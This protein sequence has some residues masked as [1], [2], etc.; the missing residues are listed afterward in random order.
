MRLDLGLDGVDGVV[1][2]PACGDLVGGAQ[3]AAR[4]GRA[5][6]FRARRCR[7]LEVARLL[8]GLLGQLDDRV[9]HRLEVPVAEHDGAEHDVFGQFLGFRLDHQH[10]VGGAGDD[11]V[12]LGLGHLV[13]RAD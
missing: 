11:E 5:F 9:D 12:E 4:R 8:G 13:D 7:R 1:A 3:V 6:R 2:R 10:G